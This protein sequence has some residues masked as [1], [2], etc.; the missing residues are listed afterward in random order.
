[1]GSG[2]RRKGAGRPVGTGKFKGPTK[3]MRVPV[4]MENSIEEFVHSNGQ[5][6][7]YYSSPVQA[8]YP[9]P[10]DDEYDAERINLYERVVKNPSHTFV[11]TANGDSMIM[12]GINTG[13][14]L[15]VDR[16]KE[17][18]D[19]AVVIASINGDFT[20]KRL[21]YKNRQ[22]Y[23]MPENKRYKPIPVKENDDVHI[24]GVVT[25]SIHSVD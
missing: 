10:V 7:A 5:A 19:G 4:D 11:L 21:K 15:V 3:T 12:A 14:L 9:S 17:I 22:P 20:V 1:M 16:K 6:I 25:H 23:L 8:G 18:K 13:D 24:F 2:G